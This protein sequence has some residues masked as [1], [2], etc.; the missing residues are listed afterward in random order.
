MG[1]KVGTIRRNL[2]VPVTQV[3][4]AQSWSGKS[5]D[6]RMEMAEKLRWIEGELEIQLLL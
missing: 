5:L 3:R 4:D 1:N 2:F 6:R